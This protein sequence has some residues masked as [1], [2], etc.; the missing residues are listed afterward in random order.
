MACS[1]RV[2]QHMASLHRREP[3]PA[4]KEDEPTAKRGRS[5]PEEPTR[6]FD[7]GRALRAQFH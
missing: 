5:A 7:L 6:E 4:A 2:H 3:A 1:R